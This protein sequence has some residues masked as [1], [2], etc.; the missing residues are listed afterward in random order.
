[1]CRLS[2][3]GPGLAFFAPDI[4]EVSTI[5]RVAEFVD[6][7][8]RPLVLGFR[9]DR[10]NRD[11]EP[12]WPYRLL[13]R[14]RDG[15]HWHR[16]WALALAVPK[17]LRARAALRRTPVYY[18]RNIDLLLLAFLARFLFNRGAVVAY[19]V[20]DIQPAFLGRGCTAVLLRWIERRC[21]GR[22]LVLVLS[23]PGFLRNY[24][25]GQLGYTGRWVLLENKLHR[26]ALVYL[27]A[28][29]DRRTAVK[30]KDAAGRWV[31]GYFGLIRG[32]ATMRLVRSIATRVPH[33]VSFRFSGVFTTVEERLF[34]AMFTGLP[35]VVYDG[36]YA[37]PQDL[38]DIYGAVDLAWAIDL[39]DSQCNSRWLL[40]NRFYEAGI[41][42]V[43]CLAVAGF[44]LG[45]ALDRL[46][47][48]WSFAEPLEDA[49][50]RF[51]ESLERSEYE[52]CR[53]RLAAL[54]RSRFVA[55]DEIAALCAILND[56]AGT[57]STRIAA[58]A[59][60]GG[61]LDRLP[62]G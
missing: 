53:R 38:G 6:H 40:P 56:A 17:L 15:R 48:G 21:L 39:E 4:T 9:R 45:V 2:D 42:G 31:V 16:V 23:S 34:R 37:H 12:A 11:F 10:C 52:A 22:V 26:S 28:G 5:K 27:P 57:P 60:E 36:E 13:G 55:G 41:C 46:G 25:R 62:E 35:N 18:A 59:V 54:P 19:E 33:K 3:V 50:V 8:M 1:L 43:P 29:A 14:T 44:E 47:V 24:Y 58:L 49:L 20:L 61:R 7:G 30:D 32:E 51:F